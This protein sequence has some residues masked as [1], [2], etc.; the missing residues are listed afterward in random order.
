MSN[1]F[2]KLDRNGLLK[3]MLVCCVI[4]IS[5]AFLYSTFIEE[6]LKYHN[7]EISC[8][9]N[10]SS[11]L[12]VDLYTDY[13]NG[14]NEK[15]KTTSK[16]STNDSIVLLPVAK[17]NGVYLKKIRLDFNTLSDTVYLKKMVLLKDKKPW[18]SLS[19]KDIV[20]KVKFVSEGSRV[21][22]NKNNFGVKIPILGKDTYI[23]FTNSYNLV[24]S[25]FFKSF[26]LLWPWFVLGLLQLY[27]HRT[28]FKSANIFISLLGLFILSIFLKESLTT[29]SVIL[30]GLFSI[31]HVIRNKRVSIGK[32]Q[33]G[34]LLFFITILAFGKIQS[35]DQINV[36]MGLCIIPIFLAFSNQDI[37]KQTL[38][39][40]YCNVVLVFMFLLTTAFLISVFINNEVELLFFLQN[41]KLIIGN[42]TYWLVYKNATFLSFF[43]LIGFCLCQNLFLENKIKFLNFSV[44]TVLVFLTLFLLGSRLSLIAFFAVSMTMFFTIR[45]KTLS[46]LVV[47]LCLFGYIFLNI[48]YIDEYRFL[49][50]NEIVTTYN[51]NF[52]GNGLGSTEELF[53]NFDNAYFKFKIN[54]AHNQ[55]ITY[56]YELGI[57]GEIM[58]ICFFLYYAVI[59]FKSKQA[60]RLSILFLLLVLMITESPFE[61]TK[62]L[63]VFTFFISLKFILPKKE[64]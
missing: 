58:L 22:Y 52:F 27:Q 12:S 11:A 59:Y 23:S 60:E 54:H 32:E 36:Q 26:L 28:H 19:G 38:Y 13:G 64:V 10:N 25:T 20:E 43:V 16:L 3:K 37:R 33:L 9:I 47:F 39:N 61:S 21:I 1:I 56:L 57:L 44:F 53:L 48:E 18:I 7:L 15:N 34:V 14:F 2:D 6:Q 45:W 31:I 17:E 35:Y 29:F 49:M 42:I 24:T 51:G 50:W 41:K 40:F 5:S 8:E 46:Y 63:Y 4:S 62:P 55:F 30:I